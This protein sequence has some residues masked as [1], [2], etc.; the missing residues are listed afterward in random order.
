VGLIGS[1]EEVRKG[2][3]EGSSIRQVGGNDIGPAG[4][5]AG[6]EPT[7][8][9]PPALGR[10]HQALILKGGLGTFV[11]AT[12]DADLA[13]FMATACRGIS[14]PDGVLPRPPY[15]DGRRWGW[16]RF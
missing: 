7:G 12:R 11:G 6:G 10:A 9:H 8:Q 14:Y 1:G 13:F 16:D 2:S 3:L 4:I 5:E 15:Q